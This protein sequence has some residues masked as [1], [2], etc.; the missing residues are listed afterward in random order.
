MILK[1]LAILIFSALGGLLYHLG[2]MGAD[3]AKK[4]PKVPAWLFNTK[5]RDAG[6]SLCSTILLW[7]LV[8]WSWWLIPVFGLTWGGMSTYWKKKGHDAHTWNWFLHGFMLGLAAF[9]MFWAGVHWYS[10]LG[11]AVISGLLM[12]W[13]SDRTGRVAV[14]EFG[15]GA[16]HAATMIFLLI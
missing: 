15:R 7:I 5:A 3:G 13:I 8:G 16:I 1:I 4:Y 10:I 6:S 11:R 14:E 12:M 2:G 9:P